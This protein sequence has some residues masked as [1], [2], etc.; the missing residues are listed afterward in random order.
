MNV[1]HP[2]NLARLIDLYDGKIDETG[3]IID[4]PDLK[5][6]RGDIFSISVSD[7]Q[8]ILAIKEAFSKHDAVLE[9]HGAVGWFALQQFLKQENKE[10]CVSIETAH[11]AKFPETIKEAIGVE[12]KPPTSLTGLEEK[13]EKFEKMQND[14]NQFKEFMLKKLSQ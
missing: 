5:K 14:Y 3:K 7:K 13:Q 6:M 2:S 1:G 4:M 9:P 12:P 8:T 11:P 10:F